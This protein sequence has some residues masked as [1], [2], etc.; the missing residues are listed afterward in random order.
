VKITG[1]T[2]VREVQEHDEVLAILNEYVD[3]DDFKAGDTLKRVCKK[4][5]MAFSELRTE[6]N[7]A[8]DAEPDDWDDAPWGNDDNEETDWESED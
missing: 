7:E 5:G 8:L 1:T 3:L 2:T 6:L 4:A